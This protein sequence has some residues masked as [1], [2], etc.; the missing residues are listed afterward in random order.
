MDGRES[1]L[2]L[3]RAKFERRRQRLEDA[4]AAAWS[5]WSDAPGEHVLPAA[6][7]AAGTLLVSLILATQMW[8]GSLELPQFLV[9]SLS[10]MLLGLIL[11]TRSLLG[12]DGPAPPSELGSVD[13]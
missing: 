6:A 2:E 8:V 4:G 7:V 12:S 5:R 11:L 9:I 13:N 10:G 3:M 1:F